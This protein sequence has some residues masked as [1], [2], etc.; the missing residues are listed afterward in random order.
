MG[1]S[2]FGPEHEIAE[3][4]RAGGTVVAASERTARA[5]AAAFNRARRAEGLTAWP[6]PAIFDWQTF[7]RTT[8]QDRSTGDGRLVLDPLQEQSI[9][10][11]IVGSDQH[12]AT[13]LEGPRNRM[14]HLA[15]EAHKLLCSYAPH[16]LR[17]KS[18][19]SWQQDAENFSAWLAAFEE[20]CR[21][22]NLLSP[23]RLP[24]ELIPLLEAA[25]G[26]PPLLLAGFDR[27]LPTQRRLFDAWGESQ[28][29]CAG[30][31][32]HGIRFY[33]TA[34]TQSEL[35]ACALWCKKH[36]AANPDAN[37]LVITQDLSE[38]RG[39]I[40]RAFLNF[41]DGLRTTSP[42]F[43]FSLGIPLS[44]VTLAR[45]AHLLLRWLSSPS[46]EN[47][48][49][50]HELD[51]LLSTG[52]TTADSRE[53]TALQTYV[54][55]L[56]RRGL[57]SPSWSLDTFVASSRNSQLPPAWVAR[58]AEAQ[59]R[60][61]EHA[62]TQKT[63]LEWAE[64][65][66]QVLRSA[67]WPGARP[68]SSVEFQALRQWR[69]TVE[70]CASLGF[71]GRRVRWR[72]FL[73][74]LAHALD[75][76]LF[77]PESRQA[78]IQIAGP[79]ES[80]GLTADAIWFMGASESAWPSSAATHPLLPPEVQREAAMPH[81][82]SQLDWELARAITHRLLRSASQV[83]FS[84]A[85]QSE[86]VEARHSRLIEQLALKP[87]DLPA[88]LA[89]PAAPE[90]LT[91]PFEDTSQIPFP[92]GK[93]EGGASVLTYQSQCPFKAFANARLAAKGWEP[94][95][96]GLTAAQRGQLLHAVLHAIWAGP[97]QGIRSLNDLQT[98]TDRSA[99]AAATVHRV[100][101]NELRPSL[102]KRMP[103]RY[104]ELEAK[105]LTRLVTEWLDFEST[106]IGFEVDETEA[107]RTIELAGLT[108]TL[109][110]DR[111][112]R[113]NDNSLL[114]I[115]Y[116]TGQVTPKSWELP[117]PDDVQLPLYAGF[118]LG[119]G[120]ELGGLVFAK[121]R[122]ND[123]SFAGHVGDPKATLLANLGN[124]SALVKNR[125]DATMLIDWRQRIEQLAEDFLTGRAEVDPR[126]YP[127]TCEYCGLETLCR[128]SE[129]Q[130]LLEFEQDSEEDGETADE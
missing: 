38:R 19:A 90:P 93:V 45:G 34:D 2:E 110:L 108:F 97:P 30:T 35:A 103:R 118:A 27:I 32:A 88:E 4:L 69:Q 84:Y 78:P 104:L 73:S 114:V 40:E 77:V 130:N 48:I 129:N 115:D 105:R 31:P 56:R 116:K 29:A 57:E 49:A 123:Q 41:A 7:L 107:E 39:E 1:E 46:E 83:C 91:V 92:P 95:Q 62:R 98:L 128:I 42:L 68:L 75:E 96:P 22:G 87:L 112:D 28:Q 20:T 121:I 11:G 37:L 81:A 5:L 79:A 106:R 89:A 101:E 6:A 85:R 51:W 36:L 65:I 125:F 111:I 26:R 50:E 17:Q 126:D 122:S 82:T 100:L 10:A 9:W 25:T 120:E 72:E 15:I 109:R 44:Q 94:A 61:A 71:D 67:G 47:P 24:L 16:F 99:F 54:R 127:K 18:R 64:L 66:P 70:S 55:A 23:A 53:S 8:W 13:L 21:A 59:S 52:Q 76:T 43:E 33:K 80:A 58:M 124:T 3:W 119:E 12:M 113:L 74:T 117:R 63:P 14:A 86:D 60:L 102:R